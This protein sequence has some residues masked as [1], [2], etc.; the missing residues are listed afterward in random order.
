M[1]YILHHTIYYKGKEVKDY[2]ISK[3]L[4]SKKIAEIKKNQLKELEDSEKRE[5]QI[6]K[7]FNESIKRLSFL[8]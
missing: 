3:D 1:I 2:M 4:I 8:L 7:E 5:K 6:T